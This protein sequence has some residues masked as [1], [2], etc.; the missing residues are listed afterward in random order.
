MITRI[1]TNAGQPLVDGFGT[2]Q[3]GA[4]IQ[5]YLVNEAGKPTDSWDTVSGERVIPG[6]VEVLTDAS[7]EFTV[8]LWPTSRGDRILYWW[9]RVSSKDV[10]DFM[11]PLADG[12][13]SVS[14][15]V[16]QAGGSAPTPQQYALWAQ[17]TQGLA[18]KAALDAVAGTYSDGDC[19]F[20]TND[21]TP[22]N[23]G[24]W[25]KEGGVF[26]QASFD[27]VAA[28][29]AVTAYAADS[30]E[31][32]GGYKNKFNPALAQ[33][34]KLTN[35][36]DGSN[37][38][39]A[40]GMSFGKQDVSEGQTYTF[41]LPVS[42]VAQ[43]K[44]IYCYN[45]A[46]SYL[47][48][49]HPI[50][51]N[52]VAPVPPTGIVY[53]D[54]DHTV[55]FTIPVG[56]G[57]GKIQIQAVYS[58]HTT[59][60]YNAVVNGAQLELGPV[61]TVFEAYNTPPTGMIKAERVPADIA[62]LTD[63]SPRNTAL[64]VVLDATYIYVRSRWSPA[65]DL[66]QRVSYAAA[67][68]FSNNV[69]NPYDARTIPAATAAA[70]TIA[71]CA[72]GTTL[73]LQGDDAAP[74]FY[75]NTYIGANHGAQV[76]HEIT[77][78][79]HGKAVADIG[80]IWSAGGYQW[81]IMRIVDANKLWVMSQNTGGTPWAFVTAT[82]VGSTLVHVSGATN[83]ANIVPTV[84][85]LTQLLPAVKNHD[86]IIRLDGRSVIAA[87]GVYYC[88]YL[89]VVDAYDICNPASA[90][91][92]VQS[93]VGGSTQPD[94]TAAAVTSDAR[95][96]TTYRYGSNGACSV[97]TLFHAKSA[98]T[99][100]RFGI[101]Q[102]NVVTFAG[103]TLLQ[104]MPKV[105][106]IVGALKTWN[107]ADTEDITIQIETINMLTASWTDAND[108][109]DRMAQIVELAGD[110]EFGHVIG[111]GL[112]RGITAPATRK[113]TVNN[114]GFVYSSRKM[115]P[116]ADTGV[117]YPAGVMPANTVLSAVAYRSLYCLEDLPA[118]FAVFTWYYDGDDIIL[119]MDLHETV[120]AMAVPLPPWF[121]GKSATVINAS[122]SFTLHTPIV[123]GDGIVISVS[124]GYGQASIKLR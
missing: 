42:G 68:A 54:S 52:P 23:N 67:G 21:P 1:V 73:V 79:G 10:E 71:A 48:L 15:I 75:N 63:L 29:E 33:N 102:A 88:E 51:G 60:D 25:R 30:F 70:D 62:R 2:P 40:Q 22:A 104:Y 59:D 116:N 64:T 74:V 81:T 28:L 13:G 36:I 118:D 27:R 86:R 32:V 85:A 96:S 65:L 9:C 91:A 94:F 39:Y 123:T 57:I 11:A 112:Q 66:V 49:D 87:S 56:S 82:L 119:V 14:W 89:D 109:P 46:G 115:Y 44:I 7:G 83:T 78:A 69:I 105:G 17:V 103:K 45:A 19:L 5:F 38:T 76:V 99:L 93:Q 108:P 122:G 24:T 106:A 77:K 61:K 35:H 6:P 50:G 37:S 43:Q 111:Y 114:A 80:S 55:T 101:V 120:T 84:D 58:V 31:G 18:T 121:T 100:T 95:L 97:H 98:L 34:G 8:S 41:S 110:K 53:S 12:E 92:Y 90:L 16:F 20:V 72:T 3:A 124:G 117:S 26:V 47:G 107:F 4:R 113:T